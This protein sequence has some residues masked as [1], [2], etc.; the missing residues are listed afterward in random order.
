[1]VGYRRVTTISPTF[2][3]KEKTA[4]PLISYRMFG[5]KSGDFRPI[6]QTQQELLGKINLAAGSANPDIQTVCSPKVNFTNAIMDVGKD[7][8]DAW[9]DRF[10]RS[11]DFT[12][13]AVI[14]G[15]T[16]AVAIFNADCPVICLQQGNRLAVLHG[17]YRCLIPEKHD[18]L[19]IIAT[20]LTHFDPAITR[21]IVIGGIGSCCWLPEYN[22]KPEILNPSLA[23]YPAIL[24]AMLRKTGPA[25]PAG[26]SHVSVDLNNLAR[27]LLVLHGVPSQNIIMDSSCTCCSKDGSLDAAEYWSHTRYKAGKQETDGRNL[28]LAWLE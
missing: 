23:R 19:T 7:P 24:K 8:K 28:T 12:D 14:E 25:S 21:A 16:T 1:M 2:D 17:G 11:K 27:T 13:G 6:H 15:T 26:P 20:A 22:D 3:M 9:S 18:E 4:M 10:F 5:I